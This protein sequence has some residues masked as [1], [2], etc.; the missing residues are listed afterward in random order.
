MLAA[1]DAASLGTAA[2][3]LGERSRSSTAEVQRAEAMCASV[4]ET[5]GQGRRGLR[6]DATSVG[7]ISRRTEEAS[8]VTGRAVSSAREAG[9]LVERLRRASDEIGSVV[10]LIGDIAGQTNLLALNATIEAA[11]AGEA[12]RGFSV[13]A[14]EVRTSR[15]RPPAPP[16]RSPR[17]SPPSSP[18]RRR[19]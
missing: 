8:G 2:G 4:R 19:P 10:K 12:G 3:A 7:E 16:R 15:R 1:D 17:A 6:T 9:A 11:R 18:S 13:V 5:V 14:G